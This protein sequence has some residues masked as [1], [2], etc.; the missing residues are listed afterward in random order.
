MKKLI[1]ATI[2]ILISLMV[3]SQ[4]LNYQTVVRNSSGDIQKNTTVYLRFTILETETSGVLYRESQSPVTD[5]YGW[6][7]T[8][9]G[10]GTP[11]SGV[12][13]NINWSNQRYL[14]VE[15][16]NT[17]GGTYQQIGISPISGGSAGAQGPKGDQGIQGVTGPAG[18]TGPKGDKGDAGSGVKIVGSLASATALPS[19]YTGAV[20][21]M[22]I[23]QDN[24]NGH[25]WTGAAWTNIGQIRG[26]QGIEGEAGPTG[27]AGA[28]GPKGDKGDRG[29]QGPQG[30]AGPA[31][32]AGPKGDKGD[33]GSGVKI[34]GSLAS[35][36]ALPSAYTGAVGD[37]YITQ[38]NGNGHVWT[39]TTWTNVGQIRGP[40]GPQG[41]EGAAGVAGPTGPAGAAGPK[42][43]KGDRGDV[44]PKGDKGDPG[45]GSN[46]W[47]LTGNSG[48]NPNTNFIGTTDNQ[49]LNLKTNNS[50]R[51]EVK[52]N[53]LVGITGTGNLT[54]LEI[55]SGN[56]AKQVDNGKI[57]YGGFGGGNH[58]LNII[59]G[60]TAADGSD[61]FLRIW[62]NRGTEIV[63]PLDVINTLRIRGG[64]P[65]AG[66]V[67]TSDANGNA[68]WQTPG[69]GTAANAWSLSG[70]AG[71]NSETNFI[72]TTDDRDLILKRN[73]EIIGALKGN[74]IAFGTKALEN[75]TNLSTGNIGIG[76]G[77]LE[78][79]TTNSNNVGIGHLALNKNR[80]HNNI[81]V[82]AFS[83]TNDTSGTNNV[84]IGFG[85]MFN[86][87][88]GANNV[89]V[90][91]EALRA[92]NMHSNIAIGADALKNNIGGANNTAIGF[93]SLEFNK[94]NHSNVTLGAF[95]LTNDTMGANNVAIGYGAMYNKYSGDNN[96]AIGYDALWD[97]THGVGNVAIGTFAGR[98]SKSSNK[99]Y[100]EN[101]N[102]DSTRALIYGDFAADSLLLNGK[103]VVRNL[104]GIKGTGIPSG[105]S[106][107]Y[108]NSQ[109]ASGSGKIQYGGFDGQDHT[110]NI[111][112]G[113]INPDGSDRK[114]KLW[115]LG[116]TEIEGN[117][118]MTGS[119]RMRGGAPGVGKVLTSDANGNG[120]W[121]IPVDNSIT[122]EI[123]TLSLTGSTL[124]LSNG[125][126]SVTLPS[127]GGGGTT[128]T[129]G[130]GINI[131]ASNQ[132][133]NTGDTNASDD[134][135]TSTMAGG[136]LTGTYPNPLVANNAISGAKIAD[137]AVT[138]SK[139]ADN[140][141]NTSKL[142][143][144]SVT[145]DKIANN[146][147]TIDKLPSG[148]S[149]TTFLRGDGT[150]TLPPSNL[151]QWTTSGTNIYNNNSGTVSIGTSS[152]STLYKLDVRGNTRITG[153]LIIDGEDALSYIGIKGFG[154][155]GSSI[156]NSKLNLM[157]APDQKVMIGSSTPTQKLDIDGQIRIRGGN[158]ALGK[159][160]TSSAD[161]TATWEQKA[162][163]ISSGHIIAN[164]SG[165]VGIGNIS[166][167]DKLLVAGNAK[168]EV[169]ST[170]TKPTLA[171]VETEDDY[172][173]LSFQN[174][175]NG[176]Q[177][178]IAGRSYDGASG[179][180][181]S[182]LNFYFQNNQGAA[183]RMTI[184]GN[185]NVG[186]NDA[187][188]TH[189]LQVN[190]STYLKGELRISGTNPLDATITNGFNTMLFTAPSLTTDLYQIGFAGN[191]A[192][193]QPQTSFYPLGNNKIDLG[194]SSNRWRTLFSVNPINSSSDMRLKKDIV[195][196][197]NSLDLVMK[198]RPVSYT[199]KNGDPDTHLGFIAQ[200]MEKVLPE[201]V[202][203]PTSE[204]DHY[205]M[206][207]TELI[208]V[209]TK[210]IQEQQSMI[211]NQNKELAN[212]KS[213]L[214]QL[215][216]LVYSYA[217]N[218]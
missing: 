117:L 166:T 2:I 213:E 143:S 24:G 204:N 187:N 15:C 50:T 85:A 196:I 62:S 1:L 114:V 106:F 131:N 45:D 150:W 134:V 215:K 190:G 54:G 120:T 101:S 57:Q 180:N 9:V 154:E 81:A 68:S 56:T 148:G 49:A 175:I 168:F 171:L 39:G 14:L 3:K 65:G 82:G 76:N 193:G 75:N 11:L 181:N 17:S 95:T 48:T 172:S 72:G 93:K 6:L 152:P 8:T 124:S 162:W 174:N 102:A 80:N 108:D 167:S 177:W 176:G 36:S 12:F 140:A 132:I 30:V 161:G 149:N 92:N 69:S 87:A 47:S 217:E 21:D 98:N 178:H 128:Y 156:S 74:S 25:V 29:D 18:P 192:S 164:T 78:K 209:L 32:A 113:G 51:I 16:S 189:K 139:L 40:Q 88:N 35:A 37:M 179:A 90:G 138:T 202:S 73:N 116:G 129:S 26:P 33:A 184:L 141:V 31:G 133:I 200:E 153:D 206:K 83:L 46:G 23:T 214:E 61:R 41:T 59:G 111:V 119:L 135:T 173:R 210:A 198:M 100:I 44:G 183:D 203:K 7:S 22:Y 20:G 43:D 130:T 121:Q 211:E 212:L 107:A 169:N 67:L 155:I 165:N 4:N 77:A 185:G 96:V 52:A 112:G 186:I 207:Y 199:W 163:T 94:N 71:T 104:L 10:K 205:G 84:A 13:A 136:D 109:K 126:G 91:Y 63:G 86:K 197:N 127:S 188:P 145:T 60:G 191:Q 27:P 5:Q 118:D 170:T 103:V 64:S 42:G 157:S 34:V 110:L 79:T 105:I 208:P 123:Q 89:A 146:A 218:K 99:L 144:S 159:V 160:L 58:D 216:K 151:S 97:N 70:N 194:N 28:A 115:S 55:G 195:D 122:N 201:V 19:A 38:D 182:R 66:K 147:I 142:A 137:N 158:P 53:G 125:G